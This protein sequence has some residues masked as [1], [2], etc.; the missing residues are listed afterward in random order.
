[1][2]LLTVIIGLC[3]LLTGCERVPLAARQ[4]DNYLDRLGRVLEQQHANY[5]VTQLS[6]Y[7]LPERRDRLLEIAP[8]RISLIELLVDTQP[9]K[10][11]QQRVS[12]RNSILG[13]VMP[14]S[15]RLAFEG[16]LIRAIEDCITTLKDDPDRDELIVELNQ[17]VTEKRSQLHGVFW[18]AINA[19]EEFEYYLRFASEPLPV[20]DQPLEDRLGAQAL[21]Q[22]AIVGQSLPAQ[23]PPSRPDLDAN[24]LALYQSDRSS[25]LIHSLSRLTH[26]LEQATAML[27]NPAAARLCPM[28]Q[29]TSQSRILLNVF[30]LFYAGE[31]QPQMAQVQRLG[32][33][34]AESIMQL[35]SVPEIP[36]ATADYLAVLAAG[37][38]S[39]WTHYQRQITAHSEAWQRVL[40]NCGMRPG[41]AGWQGTAP[42]A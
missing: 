33:P 38:N 21:Q 23:L 35:S 25:Q 41:Q 13:K 29:P 26:T 7:R 10:P 1:M 42:D 16:E 28:G 18:N 30:V 15:H 14:W 37:E 19:S 11:M 24:F 3:L 9:C 2:R 12:E 40:G 8:M 32:R 34:W 6:R 4:M 39:L 27:G 22:L 31:I 36:S 5:D 20:Q 17:L